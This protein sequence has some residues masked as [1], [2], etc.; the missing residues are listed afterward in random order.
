MGLK[1]SLA[2]AIL[3]FPVSLGAQTLFFGEDDFS[4]SSSTAE[5]SRSYSFP[6]SSATRASF[7]GSLTSDVGT[8]TFEGLSHGL[9]NPALS[10]PGAGTASISGAGVVRDY[11]VYGDWHY[12]D[13][14]PVSGEKFYDA[15]PGSFTL[16]F[17]DPV[18]AFGFYSVDA[19]DVGGQ[20]WLDFIR[21]SGTTSYMVPHQLGVGQSTT[22]NAFYFGLIDYDNP[23][24]EVQFRIVGSSGDWFAFDDMTI[25][26]AAQVV[27]EPATLG[28]V[29]LGL[30]GVGL[31]VKRRRKGGP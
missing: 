10:F 5:N 2:A 24:D 29:G 22:G 27:P 7:L 25:A 16:S 8:E 9:V 31:S 6:N 19:G 23:F 1:T 26:S 15:N 4:F 13:R 28:L 14:Y 17:S 21:S 3:L 18:A 12:N 20:L 30:A 11:T